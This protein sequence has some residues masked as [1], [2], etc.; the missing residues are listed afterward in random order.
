MNWKRFL[1]PDWRKIVLFVI[2][3][4]ISPA[5]FINLISI[6]ENPQPT[7]LV[8]LLGG[9]FTIG[10]IIANVKTGISIFTNLNMI[11]FIL[12]III[13]YFLSCLI[14]W[15]YIKLKKK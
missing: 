2:F 4:L 15:I 8:P 6:P 9:F 11:F 12:S 14:I 7:Q 3:F 1:K 5:Q 10:L 13:S